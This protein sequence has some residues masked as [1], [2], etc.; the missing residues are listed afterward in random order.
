MTPIRAH[1]TGARLRGALAGA[2][3]CAFSL[4]PLAARPQAPPPL[5]PDT[6]GTAPGALAPGDV[7]RLRIWREPDLSGDFGVD[8]TGTVVLPRLGPTSVAGVPAA[9]LR[10][11]IVHGYTA[12][13]N[14]QAVEVTL[15][16]R[17]QVLGAVRAPGLYP[18]DATMTLGD[19]LALAGGTTPQGHPDRVVLMRRADGVRTAATRRTRVA[20][21][22]LAS[23]D[24]I[25]VPERGWLSRNPGVVGGIA[26]AV[27]G[28]I[29]TLAR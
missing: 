22:P 7:V 15:L 26:A 24:Q 9:E 17:V 12:F 13:L 10:E 18:V 27:L 5:P 25:Y 28:L 21:T 4:L 29:A 6:A 23:G 16:R 11:R 1:R 19:A 2:A 3:I 14:H 20:D 8:E